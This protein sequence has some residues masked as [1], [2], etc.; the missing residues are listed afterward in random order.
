[1]T[2]FSRGDRPGCE[3]PY[4][5]GS[6]PSSSRARAADRGRVD[7]H[8]P[9]Q[10][11][12]DAFALLDEGDEQMLRLE[13]RVVVLPRQLDAPPRPLRALFRCIC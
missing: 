8:L 13:L 3:P 1:M 6:L 11:G 4:A 12:D 5:G 7:F 9:Q 2:S 10:L